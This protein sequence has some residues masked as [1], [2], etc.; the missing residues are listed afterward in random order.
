MVTPQFA[1][2][3]FN[4]LRMLPFSCYPVIKLQD[5]GNKVLCFFS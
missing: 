1:E 2:L 3:V 5:L 4:I